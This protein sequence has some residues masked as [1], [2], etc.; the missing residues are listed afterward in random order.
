MNEKITHINPEGLMKSPAFSQIVT[1]HGNGTTIHIGGQNAVNAQGEII[2]QGD[3]AKQTEQ[4]LQNLQIALKACNAT[5]ENL[6]KLTIYIMQGQDPAVGFQA[7]QKF[8]TDLQN[9]PAI[10]GVLVAGLANPDFLVEIDA[11]AFVAG[12]KN[13]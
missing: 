7:S 8:F 1:T 10:T 6:V 12:H 3:L 5:F 4:V 2:G 11:V 9:P 13:D